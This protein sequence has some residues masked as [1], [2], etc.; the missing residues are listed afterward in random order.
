[1][2]A[3][4]IM[5]TVK[6]LAEISG[7]RLRSARESRGLTQQQVADKVGV[8]KQTLSNYECEHGIPSGNVLLRLCMLYRI[9]AGQLV[10]NN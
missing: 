1:M 10:K 6:T 5:D 4:D 8:T 2:M 3:V 7:D 9:D